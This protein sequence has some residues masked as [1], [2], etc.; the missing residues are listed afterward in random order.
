MKKD[1]SGSYDSSGYDSS[2]SEEERLIGTLAHWVGGK[3]RLIHR[4]FDNLPDNF[5][6]YFEPFLGGGIVGYNMVDR[7]VDP[8]YK[9]YLNDWNK[10]VININ[11]IVAA[12]PESLKNLLLKYQKEYAKIQETD[13]KKQYFLKKKRSNK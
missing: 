1:Y 6:N 11:K 12:N 3:K 8:K 13:Q 10:D 7:Y 5:N 9:A 4:I 2:S